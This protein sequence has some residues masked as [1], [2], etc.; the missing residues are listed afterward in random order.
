MTSRW[1]SR[2]PPHARARS[3]QIPVP[4]VPARVRASCAARTVRVDQVG[5]EA[6]Y[7]SINSFADEFGTYETRAAEV[8][9]Q[10]QLFGLAVMPWRDLKACRVELGLLK[11]VWDHVQLINDIF[12]SF[13]N[14]LWSNVDVE[15]MTDA[16]KKLM[17]ELKALPKSVQKWAVYEGL[18]KMANSMG[19]ALPLVQDLRDDAMRPRHW[20]QLMQ[21]TQKSF[22]VDD[23]AV[24]VVPIRIP[25]PKQVFE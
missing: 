8:N 9:A 25:V 24:M 18:W 13:R 6:A 17:K 16:T 5:V 21:L 3:P 20:T 12:A 7:K 10:Q 22:V 15:W 23:A 2:Q 1:A 19:I 11:M 4:A 14:A